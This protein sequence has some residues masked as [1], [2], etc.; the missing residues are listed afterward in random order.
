MTWIYP[1]ANCFSPLFTESGPNLA[2]HVIKSADNFIQVCESWNK[3]ALLI[4]CTL[5]TYATA[6]M[7]CSQVL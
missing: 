4:F 3:E 5:N 1:F 6:H 7:L 2:D